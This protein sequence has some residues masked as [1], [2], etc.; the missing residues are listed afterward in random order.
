LKLLKATGA[1]PHVPEN[2]LL[3]LVSDEAHLVV[4][5]HADGSS[6]SGLAN[7]L[8]ESRLVFLAIFDTVRVAAHW[9]CHGLEVREELPPAAAVPA[10]GE[11]HGAA[12][13]DGVAAGFRPDRVRVAAEVETAGRP[14]EPHD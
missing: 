7:P 5:A 2:T 8:D 9:R 3:E 6:L 14:A 4:V 11:T 13:D 12:V 10:D 1:L